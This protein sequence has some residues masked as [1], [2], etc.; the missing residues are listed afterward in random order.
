MKLLTCNST[1]EAFLKRLNANT[2]EYKKD[3]IYININFNDKEEILSHISENSFLLYPYFRKF[4][5]FL[6]PK[7]FC[8]KIEESESGI[9]IS[10]MLK[11]T[12]EVVSQIITNMLVII[13]TLISAY[14]KSWHNFEIEETAFMCL[15]ICLFFFFVMVVAVN[16]YSCL[17][18]KEYEKI[19]VFLLKLAESFE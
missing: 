13:I 8:C 14:V 3:K 1:K 15:G 18:K 16:I 4:L 12:R 2:G 11:F 19:Y 10:G 17:F 7:A 9:N 5:F 6:P